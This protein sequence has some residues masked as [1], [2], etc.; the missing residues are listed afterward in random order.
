[1]IIWR[2]MTKSRIKLLSL[3]RYWKMKSKSSD[4]KSLPSMKEQRISFRGTALIIRRIQTMVTISTAEGADPI[5]AEVEGN[6]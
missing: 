5:V 4:P 1:M 2:Q 6:Y 3:T